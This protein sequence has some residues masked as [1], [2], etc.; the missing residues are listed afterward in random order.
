MSSI[1]FRMIRRDAHDSKLQFDTAGEFRSVERF[2]DT[3]VDNGGRTRTGAVE[4]RWR[5]YCQGQVCWGCGL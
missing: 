2:I 4:V 3:P 1:R 5:G